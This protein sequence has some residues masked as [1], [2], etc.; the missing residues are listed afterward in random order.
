[1]TVVVDPKPLVAE[2][3]S[4][5]ACPVCGADDVRRWF[6][7]DSASI[8][9]CRACKT[10]YTFEPCTSSP[11]DYFREDYFQGDSHLESMFGSYRA[12]A[13]RQFG[14]V[15]REYKG[16]GRLLDIGCAAGDF[17]VTLDA[18][19]WMAV[20]VEP[21]TM[22]TAKA[23]ARGL[24]VVE[25][26]FGAATLPHDRFDA[27]TVLDM[28]GHVED[29]RTLMQT[30]T[31]LLTDH[32]VVLIEVPGFTFR[33]IK[34]TGPIAYWKYRRWCQLNPRDFVFFV[35]S[36]TMRRLLDDAG[37][38]LIEIRDVRPNRYGSSLKQTGF[39]A[40]FH[41]VRAIGRATGG[42]LMLATKILYVARRKTANRV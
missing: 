11:A 14:D 2:R 5:R 27:I 30:V 4:R 41:F 12:D 6:R 7:E 38:E 10:L 22:A 24:N 20:G 37:L 23:R 17:L 15:L 40:Y 9:R 3:P 28:L 13:F 39:R 1:M 32:G 31:S 42:R 21:S 35:S 29:P 18:T 36:R 34:N 33:L 8:G 16:G 25:G 26:I 19:G